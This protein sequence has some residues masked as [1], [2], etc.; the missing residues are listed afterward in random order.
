MKEKK[1]YS[2]GKDFPT[3]KSYCVCES[4]T[5]DTVQ[6]ERIN[7]PMKLNRFILGHSEAIRISTLYV[8]IL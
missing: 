6:N 5:D 7:E 4:T 2:F 3:I 1:K 8:I